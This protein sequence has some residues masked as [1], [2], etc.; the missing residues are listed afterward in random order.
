MN[1]VFRKIGFI[2]IL[3][4]TYHRAVLFNRN[5]KYFYLKKA[6]LKNIKKLDFD[7]E[8]MNKIDQIIDWKSKHRFAKILLYL[9]KSYFY[10]KSI[11]K[12]LEDFQTEFN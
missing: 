8:D 10:E 1:I 9:L 4:L 3:I 6:S 5:I 7:H 11:N 12:N 2:E